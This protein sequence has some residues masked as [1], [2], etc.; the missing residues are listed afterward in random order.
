MAEVAR[1][2]RPSA[3]GELEI[4]EVN[5]HYLRE[6]RLTVTTLDRGTAWLDT[7]TFAS[8]RAATEFVSMYVTGQRDGDAAGTM[9]ALE[10]G[11]D[12]AEVLAF[13]APNNE[14][15]DVELEQ[16]WWSD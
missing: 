9:R 10:G 1:G 5:Q 3:R 4:T 11:P 12:G 16:G 2:I 6:G 7:G 8:L 13:S 15:K 14:N